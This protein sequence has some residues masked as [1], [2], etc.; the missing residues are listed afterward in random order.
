MADGSVRESP[1]HQPFSSRSSSPINDAPKSS[2]F[3][4]D[5]LHNHF[6]TSAFKDLDNGMGSRPVENLT[7]PLTW[8][9]SSPTSSRS[10]RTADSLSSALPET[11]SAAAGMPKMNGAFHLSTLDSVAPQTGDALHARGSAS[12]SSSLL[13]TL[14]DHTNA[15]NTMPPSPLP[16]PPDN[17]FGMVSPGKLETK[18]DK[19]VPPSGPLDTVVKKREPSTEG[20]AS[21][22]PQ[23]ST[24]SDEKGV[25]DQ[26]STELA[27]PLLKNS[28]TDQMKLSFASGGHTSFT[29][30][31]GILSSLHSASTTG[32]N[33]RSLSPYDGALGGVVDVQGSAA[34]FSSSKT[35]AGVPFPDMLAS[36]TSSNT[37]ALAP[38]L[39]LNRNA[40]PVGSGGSS[41]NEFS[42]KAKLS[43]KSSV[44]ARPR[45][46]LP[47]SGSNTSVVSS[48]FAPLPLPIPPISPSKRPSNSSGEESGSGFLDSH[49]SESH[50]SGKSGSASSSQFSRGS[51]KDKY[52][53][54]KE[55][56]TQSPPKNEKQSSGGS[57]LHDESLHSLA[58]VFLANAETKD[59]VFDSS[60]NQTESGK[61]FSKRKNFNPMT[62][63]LKE[64]ISA[65]SLTPR[66]A[67]TV[68]VP[69]SSS[70]ETRQA[71]S[72][73]DSTRL[74]MSN[75][76]LL[77]GKY[78]AGSDRLEERSTSHTLPPQ[79][80]SPSLRVRI[81]HP[82]SSS[83]PS[84]ERG[85]EQKGGGAGSEPTQEANASGDDVSLGN[86]FSPAPSSHSL[87]SSRR[88]SATNRVKKDTSQKEPAKNRNE[89]KEHLIPCLP[90]D[91]ILDLPDISD[92]LASGEEEKQVTNLG[93]NSG[94]SQRRSTLSFGN[95]GNIDDSL[96][97]EK[98]LYAP[99]QSLGDMDPPLQKMVSHRVSSEIRVEEGKSCTGSDAVHHLLFSARSEGESSVDLSSKIPTQLL[100]DAELQSVGRLSSSEQIFAEADR[101]EQSGAKNRSSKYKLTNLYS[102]RKNTIRSSCNPHS[103]PTGHIAYSPY[104]K[105]ISPTT[106]AVPP[107]S[108]H[109]ARSSNTGVAPFHSD[110]PARTSVSSI[111]SESTKAVGEK[112]KFSPLSEGAPHGEGSSWKEEDAEGSTRSGGAVIAANSPNQVL[113]AVPDEREK[114]NS[115]RFSPIVAVSAISPF[116]GRFSSVE[117]SAPS[118]PQHS[119][120]VQGSTSSQTVRLGS[121]NSFPLSHS[122]AS[123][124]RNR[125]IKMHETDGAMAQMATSASTPTLSGRDAHTAPLTEVL[126]S[127]DPSVGRPLEEKHPPIPTQRASSLRSSTNHCTRADGVG[128][129]PQKDSLYYSSSTSIE[130]SGR[131]LAPAKT[132]S[133]NG[134]PDV[135]K[136]KNVVGGT[137]ARTILE[138]KEQHSLLQL[139]PNASQP[140]SSSRL[141]T[142][143]SAVCALSSLEGG[144]LSGSVRPLVEGSERGM[145]TPSGSIG[146]LKSTTEDKEGKHSFHP[147]NSSFASSG[148]TSITNWKPAVSCE[149]SNLKPSPPSQRNR[150]VSSQMEKIKLSNE[151][152]LE[153]KETPLDF[154]EKEGIASKNDSL[155]AKK[156]I[157]SL[158]SL[159]PGATVS[160]FPVSVESDSQHATAQESEFRPERPPLSVKFLPADVVEAQKAGCCINTVNN[161]PLLRYIASLIQ[162]I[163]VMY[164]CI[165]LVLESTVWDGWDVWMMSMSE[166]SGMDDLRTIVLILLL[167]SSVLF[168]LT[169]WCFFWHIQSKRRKLVKA[170]HREMTRKNLREIQRQ[171][172]QRISLAA[173]HPCGSETRRPMP[174]NSRAPH[175][176]PE[177]FPLQKLSSYAISQDKRSKGYHSEAVT[178]VSQE[179]DSRDTGYVPSVHFPSAVEEGSTDHL[180][181]VEVP[182]KRKEG[183]ESGVTDTTDAAFPFH[184][185][186]NTMFSSTPQEL[187]G[188]D[189]PLKSGAVGRSEGS[190]SVMNS[191]FLMQNGEVDNESDLPCCVGPFHS[192]GAPSSKNESE[193]TVLFREEN[194]KK[195]PSSAGDID[196]KAT[197]DTSKGYSLHPNQSTY[198]DNDYLRA[199]ENTTEYPVEEHQKF[200][201]TGLHRRTFF[202]ASFFRHVCTLPSMICLLRIL[203]TLFTVVLLLLMSANSLD[204]LLAVQ[205][206]TPSG[207]AWEYSINLDSAFMCN[208]VQLVGRCSGFV[209]LCDQESYANAVD[210]INAVCPFCT[211]SQQSEI[212]TF[213]KTCS[214]VY[215]ERKKVKIAAYTISLA[216]CT[217]L[218]F[219]VMVVFVSS[220]LVGAWVEKYKKEF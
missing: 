125:G 201:I 5:K 50:L 153:E 13:R 154:S 142:S 203:S 161:F 182:V 191:T 168:F 136:R 52:A 35:S 165:A 32:G 132:M 83:T 111:A 135:S 64:R 198:A 29:S 75:R 130:H 115:V 100:H 60:T 38:P 41:S 84:F 73:T 217:A 37:A 8:V 169:N 194:T 9:Q 172:D 21:A 129:E 137:S 152:P 19:S 114:R 85:E 78:P 82:S 138:S 185:A 170:A 1:P 113:E 106:S 122:S 144:P 57:Y 98:L 159:F 11:K 25:F 176:T 112:P 207:Y 147:N 173:G 150:R 14:T 204:N 93:R 190:L 104:E 216:I 128:Q 200:H 63:N 54:P 199:Q 69:S 218:V 55:R 96:M 49:L 156:P 65:L 6:K 155:M 214:T 181:K 10:A 196:L 157:S 209:T 20:V 117:R 66:D 108:R 211:P 91:D 121:Q 94:A 119:S 2:T 110:S 95:I 99:H 208:E 12:S 24:F 166:T 197:E 109:G 149:G 210:A 126:S 141:G 28:L 133:S 15:P 23:A 103:L 43:S 59:H 70:S 163:I 88:S 16:Q 34:T 148:S 7:T 58:D 61:T 193:K 186:R 120:D 220:L 178:L 184:D 48:S 167:I 206:S 188:T 18:D 31:Q 47:L 116:S 179:H 146:I 118:S 30:L 76:S 192:K 171:E 162:L 187:D 143:L 131:E 134:V 97:E 51:T 80:D 175:H 140:H 4:N 40:F 183:E 213:T 77:Q 42:A 36:S 102:G 68:S 17:L 158:S 107:S 72:S 81:L 180:Q 212:A 123:P 45:M 145:N 124:F 202:F 22:L 92:S 53:L 33:T 164:A 89:D 87:S 151:I 177:K 105:R 44:Q 86:F 195:F 3:G 39:A 219:A 160:N 79:S 27:P 101:E 56:N 67:S 127:E 62:G 174:G 205:L 215:N 74:S 46:L 189:N 139:T 26:S 71:I 90:S